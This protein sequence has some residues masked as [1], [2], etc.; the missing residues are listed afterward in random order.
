MVFLRSLEARLEKLLLGKVA[1]AIAETVGT[2]GGATVTQGAI[3]T[4]ADAAG[5]VA[6]AFQAGVEAAAPAFSEAVDQLQNTGDNF[7]PSCS[8]QEDGC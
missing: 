3:N 6:G 2:V 8:R 4:G 7:T 1:G 5:V